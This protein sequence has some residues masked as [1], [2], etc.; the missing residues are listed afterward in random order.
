[1]TATYE[2]QEVYK[3]LGR[4]GEK[5]REKEKECGLKLLRE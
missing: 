2:L 1:L 3:E 5:G 4:R